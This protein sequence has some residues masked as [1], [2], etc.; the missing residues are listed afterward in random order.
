MFLFCFFFFSLSLFFLEDYL[1]GD[2]SKGSSR[3]GSPV[4]SD[5]I[6]VTEKQ[7]DMQDDP[8]SKDDLTVNGFIDL[9]Y[10]KRLILSLI[11]MSDYK[12]YNNL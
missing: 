1:N 4:G 6:P 12:I 3:A 9:T 7:L 11:F 5:D 8:E 10:F 2:G